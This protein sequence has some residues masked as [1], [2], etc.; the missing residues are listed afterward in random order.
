MMGVLSQIG[1]DLR[2]WIRNGEQLLLMLVLPIAG[3]VFGTPR[4][5]AIGLSQQAFVGTVIAVAV[6]GTAFTGQSILTAFDRRA[7]ALIV[8]GAG[9]LGRPGFVTARVGTAVV[10]SLGQIVVLATVGALQGVSVAASALAGGIGLLTIPCYAGAGL[11]LAGTLRAELVLA[12]ANLAYGLAAAV[13]F[14]DEQTLLRF[15]LQFSPMGAVALAIRGID[16]VA[17]GSFAVTCALL[18]IWATIAWT[19]AAR[20][21]RWVE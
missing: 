11:L 8:L 10:I 13:H 21:F 6:M 16:G 3:I 19:G 15:G 18:V 20:W 17:T 4:A 14:L 2:I 7:G 12:L 5:A 1:L 9:P